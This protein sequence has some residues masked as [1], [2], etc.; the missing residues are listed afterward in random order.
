[1]KDIIKI[2]EL[3]VNKDGSFSLPQ[4]YFTQLDHKISHAEYDTR[5]TNGR[6]DNQNDCGVGGGHNTTCTNRTKCSGQNWDRCTNPKPPGP[7]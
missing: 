3:A 2:G 6:C 1:M 4:A 5:S 7:N